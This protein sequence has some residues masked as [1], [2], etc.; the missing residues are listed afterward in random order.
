MKGKFAK[1]QERLLKTTLVK[2]LEKK[3][4]LEIMVA[5]KSSTSPKPGGQQS[6][7]TNSGMVSMMITDG[8]LTS[9]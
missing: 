4:E 8:I 1:D 2:A 5:E 6:Q 9:R 7:T 3:A